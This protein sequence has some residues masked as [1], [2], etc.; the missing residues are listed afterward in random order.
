MRWACGVTTVPQR[1]KDLLPRTLES[2]DKAGFSKPRLFID[3][4]ETGNDWRH[5]D[6]PITCRFP[7]VRA[8]PNWMLSMAELYSREPKADRYVIFQD[9]ILAVPNLREYLEYCQFPECGYWNLC[10]YPQNLLL[11]S[12]PGWFLSNQRG[13]GAQGLVFDLDGIIELLTAQY[14]V[15]RIQDERKGWR[16]IDGGVVSC[17]RALGYKEWCHNPSL[18]GHTGEV[19]AIGNRRQPTIPFSEKPVLLR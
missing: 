2:L 16:N 4:E 1:R 15:L 7:K 3:G 11:A 17:L 8:Y 13:R 12:E 5:F 9:D 10:T 6:C 14:M 18:I 19:S